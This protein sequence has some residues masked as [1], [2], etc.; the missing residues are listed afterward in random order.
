MATILLVNVENVDFFQGKIM[1]RE[2]H[3]MI[4]PTWQSKAWVLNN[5]EH[6]ERSDK[7]CIEGIFFT[8]KKSLGSAHLGGNREAAA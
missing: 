3:E 1:E 5:S 4:S 8:L 7:I 6:F 2:S